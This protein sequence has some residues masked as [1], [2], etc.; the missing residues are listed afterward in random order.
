MTQTQDLKPVVTRSRVVFGFLYLVALACLVIGS[1]LVSAMGGE[2]PTY[3][4]T[5]AEHSQWAWGNGLTLTGIA[6]TLVTAVL[7]FVFRKRLRVG[8]QATVGVTVAGVL[9]AGLLY[10]F[11]WITFAA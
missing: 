11:A 4:P 3:D 10:F 1:A 5:T 6:L 9:L 2:L 8:L 7:L